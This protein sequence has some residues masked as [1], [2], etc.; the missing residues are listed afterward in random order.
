MRINSA[1]PR[2]L[3]FCL[4]AMPHF[5]GAQ[6]NNNDAKPPQQRLVAYHLDFSINEIAEG[7]KINSRHYSMN[8]ATQ[9]GNAFQQLKIGSRLPVVQSEDGKIQ[10]L[11]LGTSFS[12]ELTYQASEAT[13]NVNA[14]ISS[15]ADPDYRTKGPN[16]PLRQMRLGGSSPLILDK[17]MT[18]ATADDPDSK[19]EFRLEMTVTK[20]I[21]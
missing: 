3:V 20:L 16:P 17:Q 1:V 11:D 13:I 8:I 19:H 7:K 14:E 21:P 6:D 5:A 15:L 9:R 12:V 4:F 10:Y 2:L 18:V